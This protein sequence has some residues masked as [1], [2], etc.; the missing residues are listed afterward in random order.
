ML[1]LAGN[2]KDACVAMDQAA[3]GFAVDLLHLFE[4]LEGGSLCVCSGR[5]LDENLMSSCV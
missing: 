1:R 4:D 2:D 5:V 3:E